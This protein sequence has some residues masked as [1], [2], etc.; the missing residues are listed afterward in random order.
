MIGH[1][2][3]EGH[4]AMTIAVTAA[5]GKLGAEIVTSATRLTTDNLATTLSGQSVR[6]NGID[7][8]C[9]L[10]TYRLDMNGCQLPSAPRNC[11]VSVRWSSSVNV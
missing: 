6:R 5:S 10:R 7:Q 4:V 1:K 8:P 9:Y 11:E 2:G 3:Q